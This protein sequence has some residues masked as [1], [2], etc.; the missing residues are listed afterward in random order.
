MASW[1]PGPL[2]A[3]RNPPR[4]RC[5]SQLSAWQQ[6]ARREFQRSLGGANAG[7]T[8]EPP[9]PGL[10]RPL[11]AGFSFAAQHTDHVVITKDSSG[12]QARNALAAAP[13]HPL[14]EGEGQGT[15]SQLALP[16]ASGCPAPESLDK[17]IGTSPWQGK[18]TQGTW[19]PRA[20]LSPR[21]VPLQDPSLGL[22]IDRWEARVGL[23][24]SH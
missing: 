24:P 23:R 18:P 6:R 5:H 11:P 10:C 8:W 3:P 12:L 7:G 4:V 14:S 15:G 16:S 1:C 20:L 17:P 13:T 2:P 9:E 21:P 19:L 22:P